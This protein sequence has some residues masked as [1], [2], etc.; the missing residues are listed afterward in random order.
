MQLP[1]ALAKGPKDF[2]VFG[3]KQFNISIDSLIELIEQL[4]RI[5]LSEYYCDY[6]TTVLI[7]RELL[8]LHRRL[9]SVRFKYP[10]HHTFLRILSKD[11]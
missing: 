4:N 1:T 9:A 5:A 7:W 8:G 6:T 2:Q 3:L 10:N 11:G